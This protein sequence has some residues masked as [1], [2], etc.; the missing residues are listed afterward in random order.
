M[1]GLNSIEHMG[2]TGSLMT[3][4]PECLMTEEIVPKIL[5]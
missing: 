1:F 2:G 4:E 5:F 3:S